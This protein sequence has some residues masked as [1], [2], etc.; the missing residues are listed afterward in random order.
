MRSTQSRTTRPLRSTPVTGT[1]PLLRAGPPAGPASVLDPSQC[2]LLGALPV[3]HRYAAGS[4]GTCLLLFHAEAADRTHV[5]CMPDTAWPINGHSPGSSRSSD[6]TPV[7]MSSVSLST[8]QQR[9][10]YVRLPDPHLTPLT[11]PFPH[12]SPRRS[13]IQR[14]MR[15][16]EA[17]PRRAAPKGHETFIFRTAPFSE[18]P[19]QS[20][21]FH[22]QDAIPGASPRC[23]PNCAYSSAGWRR[24][25]AGSRASRVSPATAKP[26]ESW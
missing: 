16:F 26:A 22:V 12:R 7:S 4:I 10:T 25:T 11:A 5:A 2:L 19:L 20:A 6:N 3:A 17:S 9:F 24:L 21:S 13:S 23:H 15:R 18:A 8:R 14:S 1:S